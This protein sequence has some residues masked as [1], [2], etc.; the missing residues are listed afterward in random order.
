MICFYE[1]RLDSTR[2]VDCYLCSN[3]ILQRYV[4]PAFS[5]LFTITLDFLRRERGRVQLKYD[6]EYLLKRLIPRLS[7][8]KA[9]ADG[10]LQS[11]YPFDLT[12]PCGVGEAESGLMAPGHSGSFMAEGIFEPGSSRFQSFPHPLHHPA[13]KKEQ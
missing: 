7:H 10:S 8:V 9:S 4:S 6:I 11:F 2:N 5:L 3:C 1:N 13:S 12:T